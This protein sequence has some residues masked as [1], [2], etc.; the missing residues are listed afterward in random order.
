MTR[1]IDEVG[2]CYGILHRKRAR[3]RMWCQQT[4]IRS[5]KCL[6]RLLFQ[7]EVET[8]NEPSEALSERFPQVGNGFSG[9]ED[10]G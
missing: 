3:E 2:T 9:R 10:H 5:N 7:S 1:Y 8:A 4:G 6:I